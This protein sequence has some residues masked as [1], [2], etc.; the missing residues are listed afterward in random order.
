MNFNSFIMTIFIDTEWPLVE[1]EVFVLPVETRSSI[2]SDKFKEISGDILLLTSEIETKYPD[3]YM[4][5]DETPV[6]F[7]DNLAKEISISELENYLET[8]EM[9]LVNYFNT[10]DVNLTHMDFDIDKSFFE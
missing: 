6:S 9:Q 8:L 2:S 3:L 5:L 1:E 4:Y 10:H 7:N